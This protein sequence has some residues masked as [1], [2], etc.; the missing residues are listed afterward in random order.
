MNLL[1]PA[2]RYIPACATKVERHW[3]GLA[4]ENERRRKERQGTVI[5]FRERKRG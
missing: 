2:F 5:P 4:Q 1:N 3:P